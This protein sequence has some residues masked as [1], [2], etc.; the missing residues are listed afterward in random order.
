M[1]FL[2][3]R[4]FFSWC[5]MLIIMIMKC[6]KHNSVG[7]STWTGWPLTLMTCWSLGHLPARFLYYSNIYSNVHFDELFTCQ[8][9]FSVCTWLPWPVPVLVCFCI[10]ILVSDQ[11]WLVF[12]WHFSFFGLNSVWAF[13]C[14]NKPDHQPHAPQT[15]DHEP[16]RRQNVVSDIFTLNQH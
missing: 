4:C 13:S 2:D 15:A 14:W 3:D 1:F 6:I 16:N 11:T 10:E 5:K 7:P 8:P 12:L 9:L